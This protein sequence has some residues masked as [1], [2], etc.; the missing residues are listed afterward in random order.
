M[1]RR[2]I[3][4]LRPAGLPMDRLPR[5]RAE[6]A[7]AASRHAPTT[8]RTSSWPAISHPSRVR[9]HRVG[10]TPGRWPPGRD[11]QQRRH[12]YGG[13]GWGKSWAA[14]K[15]SPIP[16]HGRPASVV[17]SALPPLAIGL[18]KCE[19][20]RGRGQCCRAPRPCAAEDRWRSIPRFYRAF[21]AMDRPCTVGGEFGQSDSSGIRHAVTGVGRGFMRVATRK[22]PPGASPLPWHLHAQFDPA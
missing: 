2:F 13:S 21:S 22:T 11:P 8:T 18:R 1:S 20:R 10:T 16:C 7:D 12:D 17:L 6:R 5:Q 19:K 4:R 15:S 3:T 14:W 9:R